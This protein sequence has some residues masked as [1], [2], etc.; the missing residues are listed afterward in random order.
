MHSL[1]VGCAAARSHPQGLIYFVTQVQARMKGLFLVTERALSLSG[2][3]CAALEQGEGSALD[4]LP[5]ERSIARAC[6]H[7]R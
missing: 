6:R 1:G 5:V 3:L 4:G 7:L 2:D